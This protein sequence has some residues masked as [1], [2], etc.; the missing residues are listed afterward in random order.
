YRIELPG[1]FGHGLVQSRLRVEDAGAVQV[2]G[3]ASLAGT[4]ANLV[5]LGL[6]KDGAPGQAQRVFQPDQPGLRAVIS[7][8]SD[9][10]FDLSPG[11]G[12]IL[13]GNGA[14][15]A[16]RERRHR[17]RLQVDEVSTLFA[18]DLLPVMGMYFDGYLVAHGA[19]GDENGGLAPEDPR[20]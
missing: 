4:I 7:R 19:G 14:W 15:L 17:S 8:R 3:Q 20:C 12:A 10:L 13:A 16:T 11:Q 18:D 6:R 9:L 1:D 2:H 5:G